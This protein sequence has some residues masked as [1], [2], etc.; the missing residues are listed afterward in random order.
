[1][2]TTTNYDNLLSGPT[3]DHESF[4]QT[5]ARILRRSEPLRLSKFAFGD[6]VLHSPVVKLHGCVD[7][8]RSSLVCTR[9]GYRKLLHSSPNYSTFVRTLLATHTVLYLGFRSARS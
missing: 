5:S 9:E 8:A 6:E 1:M 3:P 7:D 2:A 4:G